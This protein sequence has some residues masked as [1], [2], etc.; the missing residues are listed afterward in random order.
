MVVA[1]G[2]AEE[3]I[4]DT[5]AGDASTRDASAKLVAE[6]AIATEGT[7]AIATMKDELVPSDFPNAQN[8]ALTGELI[9]NK[10]DL[11]EQVPTDMD[12]DRDPTIAAG[13]GADADADRESLPS[14]CSF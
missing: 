8:K 10:A 14:R 5:A 4:T 12:A 11:A 1:A 13:T 9:A 2:L 6:S 7:T 3:D